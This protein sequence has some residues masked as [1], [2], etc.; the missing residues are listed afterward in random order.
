MNRF[1]IG[2]HLLATLPLCAGEWPQYRGPSG[3]G[4]APEE[5]IGKVAG[6]RSTAGLE[7]GE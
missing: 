5:K 7:G 3:D 1:I 4:Q 6:E 2:L